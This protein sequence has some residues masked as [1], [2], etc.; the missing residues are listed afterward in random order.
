M[1][2]E[3]SIAQRYPTLE[4]AHIEIYGRMGKSV[5]RMKNLSATGAFLELQNGGYV[6]RKGDLVK[7]TVHLRTVGK[8]RIVD[9][10]VVW[11]NGLGFGVNFLKKAELLERMFQRNSAAA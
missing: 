4:T 8:S 5:A 3:R 10:E 6:P 1:E 11:N 9:A 2:K 7:A